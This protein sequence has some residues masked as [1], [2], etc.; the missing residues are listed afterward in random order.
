MG[1]IRILGE[2]GRGLET[3]YSNISDLLF[4]FS[5]NFIMKI[6]VGYLASRRYFLSITN[7]E[8]HQVINYQ[9]IPTTLVG[10][11]HKLYRQEN[12]PK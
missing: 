6:E 8:Y 5:Y 9:S 1:E 7:L 3:S 11:L 10:G 4:N 12:M 2:G